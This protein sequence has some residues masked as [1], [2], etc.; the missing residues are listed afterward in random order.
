MIPCI[1]F[2]IDGTLANNQERLHYLDE[3]PKN[4]EKY[5]AEVHKDK[6]IE[7]LCH[8]IR[9]LEL[10]PIRQGCPILYMTGRPEAT[11]TATIQW[12]FKH[13]YEPMGVLKSYD[14]QGRARMKGMID[15]V[16]Y[17]RPNEDRRP[18]VEVKQMLLAALRSE[19]M[20]P[21]LAIE[22]RRR[23]VEMWRTEGIL[24][25]QAAEGDF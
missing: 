18:D 8:L 2:D 3:D 22:D 24:C 21:L 11:R 1:V 20:E 13:I 7:P 16:L 10:S 23:V 17:M 25:L 6:P 19:G 5:H 4:W 14:L 15:S 12:L 9:F